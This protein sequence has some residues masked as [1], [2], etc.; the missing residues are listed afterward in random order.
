M[1]N[2]M[3]RCGE[4]TRT[5]TAQGESIAFS[6]YI[7]LWVVEQHAFRGNEPGWALENLGYRLVPTDSTFDMVARLAR[8]YTEMYAAAWRF[9][10][11]SPVGT[12]HR[13]PGIYAAESIGIYD[14]TPDRA[15]VQ[16]IL[17][18]F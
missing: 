7:F 16:D 2:T 11:E 5:L 9:C 14:W 12:V 18:Q 10:N 4:V 17:N 15:M 1:E 3:E 13:S 8:H 6:K